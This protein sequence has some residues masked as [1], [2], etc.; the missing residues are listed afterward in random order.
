M[1]LKAARPAANA[2]SDSS[3]PVWMRLAPTIAAL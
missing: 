2:P 3:R 1:P